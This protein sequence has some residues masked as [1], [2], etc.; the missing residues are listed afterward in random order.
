MLSS[1]LMM[2]EG[3]M[4][5]RRCNTRNMHPNH[6]LIREGGNAAIRFV[7]RI[8]APMARRCAVRSRTWMLTN[9]DDQEGHALDHRG[10]GNNGGLIG[11]DCVDVSLR[12]INQVLVV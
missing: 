2:T 8:R 6:V 1:L 3:G 9:L 4:R 10:G 5:S 7:M 11:C 12:G